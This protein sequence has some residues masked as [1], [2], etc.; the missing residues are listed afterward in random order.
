MI[1][2]RAALTAGLASAVG[3]RFT[4]ARAADT[5]GVSATEIKIGNTMPYS[6]PASS[7][8]VIGRT[9]A[10]YFKMVN[11]Q[12]GIAGRKVNFISLD[13]GYSPPKTV[14][15]VRQLVEE[16]QVDFCFQNLGTPCNSAIATYM[17]QNKIPQLFV[18]SGAS[19]W[20]DY[21]KYPWTMGWQP[22]YRTE[23]QIYMKYMLANVKEPKLGILY[24]NDDFGKDYP[25][26]ARDALG[27]NWDKIVVKSVSYETTDATVDSQVAELQSSGANVLL[28]G[29]IPKF[30]AQAIRKVYDL[31]W[32]P[33]FFMTNVAISVGTVM[34]PAGPEKAIGML[35]T[36]YLK[37]PTDPAWKDDAAMNT[38][39]GFMAKYNP[40][41]DV[42]DSATVFAYG[43][44]MTMMQVLKQC[45]G[46]FS[47]ANVMKQAESLHDVDIPILLPGIKLSTAATDHRPIKAMQLQRWDGK[48]WVRFGDLIE[49]ANA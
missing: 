11:D 41:G 32:K 12:G 9:E 34:Q 6:G 4:S 35:S 46:D 48:T 31:N 19:K 21:K 38:W 45:N 1:T 33:M 42:T 16:D 20:S 8:S 7:Y 26:G 15:D 40:S 18:G 14:E 44:S 23:A 28:V 29:A 49:G 47:R 43:I 5:P 24:Q 30:A 17:N 27:A 3:A 37:D 22:N 39:R 2:R 25:I 10:A 13:D 36:Q